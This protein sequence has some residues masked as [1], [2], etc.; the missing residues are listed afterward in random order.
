M[1]TFQR[2]SRN[3]FCYSHS[4][5]HSMDTPSNV[6]VPSDCTPSDFA[7]SLS[8]QKVEE[9]SLDGSMNSNDAFEIRQYVQARPKKRQDSLDRNLQ[10]EFNSDQGDA[11]AEGK[12]KKQAKENKRK[13]LSV[14]SPSDL[15]ERTYN[16]IKIA[17][18]SVQDLMEDLDP[19][20]FEDMFREQGNDC[21]Y[22]NNANR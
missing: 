19:N 17:E 2:E 11:G 4:S 18:S 10:E 20:Y 8:L 22:G 12:S 3:H 21:G 16:Q 9:D 7:L 15:S 14:D 5:S 13:Y 1:G 6:S